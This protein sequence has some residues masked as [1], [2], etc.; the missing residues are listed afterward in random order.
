MRNWITGF[1]AIFC[2]LLSFTSCNKNAEERPLPYRNDVP[3]LL[4]VHISKYESREVDFSLDVA[5]YKGDNDT[6]RVAEYSGIPADS[7]KFED[8][9]FN[10]SWVRHSI[11]K[12]TYQDTIRESTFSTLLMIDQSVENVLSLMVS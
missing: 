12:M 11:E 5:V 7:F 6:N 2:T 4:A 9:L 3:I 8:Y 10:G 1:I